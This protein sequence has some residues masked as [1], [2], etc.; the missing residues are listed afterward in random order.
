MRLADSSGAAKWKKKTA[1]AEIIQLVL[2]TRQG[3]NRGG[4]PLKKGVDSLKFAAGTDKGLLREIN[5]DSC[6]I[7]PGCSSSPYVF[8]I[9]DGMGGH[10]CGEIASSMTVDY[11]SGLMRNDDGRFESENMQQELCSIVEQ[12]NKAVYEKSQDSDEFSGMGTTLTMAVIGEKTL[13]AAHVGDSR[14]YLVRGGE[15][16]QLTEDHSYIGEL[17]K[18]GTL[19][20]EEAENHPRK[21]VITRAIGSSP[22]I[23]VDIF[24]QEINENDIYVLCTDGLTNMVCDNEIFEIVRDSEPETA[25]SKL[26]EAANRQGGD[27]NITVIV[28]KCE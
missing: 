24:N 10:K 25:C 23:Q 7:I 13:T 26:I 19:T 11:I 22:E 5:E 15:I 16:K 27:D 2:C 20:R 4:Q 6:R 18:N 12:A 3:Q 14:L 21:N 17:L 8:I 28:I 1:R 9:A